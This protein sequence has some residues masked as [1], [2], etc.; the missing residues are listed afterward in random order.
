MKLRWILLF[1]AV[2]AALAAGLAA[3]ALPFAGRWF[4]RVLYRYPGSGLVSVEQLQLADLKRGWI[5]RHAVYQTT[6]D[7]STAVAWYAGRLPN[8][9]TRFFG[10]CVTIRQRGSILNGQT[11]LAIQL[12]AEPPGTRILVNEEVCVAP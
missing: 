11:T 5:A 8:A 1:A 3:V 2:S 4:D 6:T 12:C 7:L 10:D 9:N